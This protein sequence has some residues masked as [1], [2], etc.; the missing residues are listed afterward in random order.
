M[1]KAIHINT[2]AS[3]GGA[4]AVMQYLASTMRLH[5]IHSEILSAE[6]TP[7]SPAK[8]GIT[9]TPGLTTACGWLGLPDCHVQKSHRLYCNAVLEDAD[10]L[11]LH[12]LHGDYFNPWSL[13]LLTALKP[14]VWTLHDMAPLTGICAQSLGC[15]CWVP[16]AGCRDC[17]RHDIYPRR[18]R[19]RAHSLWQDRQ[20]IYRHSTFSLVTPSTWLQRLV[21]K[22]IL[23]DKPLACIPNGVDT[24]VFRPGDKEEARRLLGLPQDALLLGGCAEGGIANPWKGGRFALETLLELKQQFPTLQFLNIGVKTAPEEFREADWAHHIPY[25]HEPSRLARLYTSLDLLLYPTLADNHPLVC[26]ESLCCGTPVVGFATGGVPEIVR[27]GSDGLLVPTGDG[28][29]LTKAAAALLHDGDWR[30]RMAQEAAVSAAQRFNLELFGQRYAKVYEA[31]LQMPRS[32][33]TSRLPL[34]KVPAL[35]KSPAFMRQERRKY[36]R[37]TLLERAEWLRHSARG[38]AAVSVATIAGWLLHALRALRA[39]MFQR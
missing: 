14:T 35:I 33:K 24:A 29:A 3:Y 23:G 15:Q 5:D 26:I 6:D 19:S 12:N 10:F 13:P 22:S 34:D 18:M 32:L 20:T 28:D 11:H 16:P 27:H 36:P 1:M 9:R 38:A 37:P 17:P 39:R 4:A 7:G 21:E 31:S 25:I 2:T 30:M 8:L